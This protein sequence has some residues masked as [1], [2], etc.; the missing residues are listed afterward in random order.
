MITRIYSHPCYQEINYIIN[1]ENT[2][3]GSGMLAWDQI[4]IFYRE[5]LEENSQ[6][7]STPKDHDQLS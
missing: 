7:A 2:T 4:R 5:A 1:S 3:N 6:K